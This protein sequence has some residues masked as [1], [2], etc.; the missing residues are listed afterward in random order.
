MNK[1]T[2]ST[3][4]TNIQTWGKKLFWVSG[5]G[6][7]RACKHFKGFLVYLR[8]S[9][10]GY[11]IWRKKNTSSWEYLHLD[12]QNVHYKDRENGFPLERQH[13]PASAGVSL[14]NVEIYEDLARRMMLVG[15]LSFHFLG[16]SD[17]KMYAFF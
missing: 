14:R 5:G 8:V 4:G 9:E 17:F 12:P 11:Y 15:S 13:R 6:S 3:A 7:F 2:G 16:H 1:G 10:N